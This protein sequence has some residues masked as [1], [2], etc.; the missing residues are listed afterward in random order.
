M[1]KIRIRV[2]DCVPMELVLHA[3][4]HLV[5]AKEFMSA[6]AK[7]SQRQAL[8]EVLILYDIEETF[9]DDEIGWVEAAKLLCKM[10]SQ[11][12]ATNPSY[13]IFCVGNHKVISLLEKEL[14]PL[15][16]TE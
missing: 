9:G 7:A 8:R 12:L 10:V 11:F 15:N 5:T 16:K 2:T 1:V 14:L 13:K 6:Y 3:K 4:T